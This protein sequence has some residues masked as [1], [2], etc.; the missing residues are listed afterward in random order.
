MKSTIAVAMS[1]GIDSL[2]AAYLLKKQGYPVFGIHF[3]TGYE[4][5]W[6]QMPP[7]RQAAGNRIGPVAE[8]I[9]IEL[10]LIDIAKDFQAEVVDY[11]THA[12]RNG[13]TPNPCLRCNPRI[14]FGTV[15]A[16]A[17]SLGADCLATG[18]YA[19]VRTDAAGMHH[20]HRGI[21]STKDQSYFLGFMT[22]KQLAHARF[23]LGG[24]TKQAVRRLAEEKG[25]K[26]ANE[27]E[28]QD[29]CFIR[30][31]SYGEFMAA[32]AGFHA[33]PGIIE[34]IHG[35]RLG[36]HPGLHLF[37]VGQRRGIN[38]PAA[39]PY[40]VVRLDGCANR[41]IVGGADS[42]KRAGCRVRDV[43]W[44]TGTPEAPF[45][46]Q[47]RLR[48]RHQP[49]AATVAPLADGG[50]YIRFEDPQKAVTP[51]QG[52]VFYRGDEVLGGGWICAQEEEG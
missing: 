4:S 24:L 38:C 11:F 52:A 39:E 8:Q 49:V 27:R 19:R 28:S 15:L 17:R 20:L 9:G 3:L 44:I 45:S 43:N 6:R 32:Q 40:Y 22:Q 50:A 1:G 2:M 14:K 29:I 37:T 26:P 13:R 30:R 33:R 7:N 41:L 25:L 46:A 18:H 10:R 31:G 47:V 48:Y 12:Y 23:P 5:G 34:D 16:H 36:E 42:L 21:D 35:N 51:G